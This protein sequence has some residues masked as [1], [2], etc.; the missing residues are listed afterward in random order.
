MA[1]SEL[2]KVLSLDQ[3]Q[4]CIQVK[5]GDSC[6][7]RLAHSQAGSLKSLAACSIYYANSKPRDVVMLCKQGFSW[8]I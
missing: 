2:Q 8:Y 7:S 3:L 6:E 4:Y 5:Y 1:F